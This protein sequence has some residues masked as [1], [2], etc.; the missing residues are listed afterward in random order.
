MFQSMNIVY[1]FIIFNFSQ[2][3]FTV[4]SAGILNVIYYMYSRHQMFLLFVYRNITDS[5]YCILFCSLLDEWIYILLNLLNF[6]SSV[7]HTPLSHLQIM[8]ALLLYQSLFF[9]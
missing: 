6:N 7:L 4:F 3:C 1:P 9:N 5:V 8:T 2:Q